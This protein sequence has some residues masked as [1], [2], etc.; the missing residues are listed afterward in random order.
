MVPVAM[1]QLAASQHQFSSILCQHGLEAWRWVIFCS[2]LVYSVERL[3][4]LEK[5][6]EMQRSSFQRSKLH[7]ARRRKDIKGVQSGNNRGTIHL[8]T[9][10][11]S[12]EMIQNLSKDFLT[13]WYLM[14][15]LKTH[16]S[17]LSW[18]FFG[19]WIT[20]VYSQIGLFTV[21]QHYL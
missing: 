15:D 14:R 5:D 4:K 12:I 20:T 11:Y 1:V 8:I 7:S 17:L 19:F 10:Q 6:T 9:S 18:A 3:E 2:S 16:F 21:C 13:W